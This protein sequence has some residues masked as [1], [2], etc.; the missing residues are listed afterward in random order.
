MP[1]DSSLTLPGVRAATLRILCEPCGRR[2]RYHV[3][4]LMAGHGD[5][6]RSPDLAD[7]RSRSDLPCATIPAITRSIMQAKRASLL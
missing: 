7:R 4:K 6:G 5:V 1:R 2:G 3:E